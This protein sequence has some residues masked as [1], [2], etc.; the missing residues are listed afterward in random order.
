M[1]ENKSKKYMSNSVSIFFL[2]KIFNIQ[3][4]EGSVISFMEVI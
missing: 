1:T 3:T 4:R 2:L